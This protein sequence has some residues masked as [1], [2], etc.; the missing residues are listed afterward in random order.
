M[1]NNLHYTVNFSVKPGS[2]FQTLNEQMN[3]VTASTQKTTF[4]FGDL[5]KKLLSFNQALESVRNLQS[6]L[7]ETIQPGIAL[8]TSLTDLSAITGLTGKSLDAI[9]DAARAS[10]EAFGTDAAQNVESYK[11][12]LSQLSPD[13]AKNAEAL[14][15][16]GDHVNTL[17]KT[18]GGSTVA[19]TE[20]LTTAMNQYGVSLDDP[21]QASKVMAEMMNTMAAAAKEGSAE[22]PQIKAALENVGMVAKTTGVTFSETNAAIQVLDKAGKKGAEGGIALR[23][24][25]STL[26]EGRFLPKQTKAELEAAGVSIAQL[27][28]KSSPLSNRLNALKPIIS[29]TALITKL[30]GKENSAAAIALINGTEAIDDYNKKIQNTNT[31]VEQAKVVMGSYAEQMKRKAASWDNW[32]IGL[33]GN[34]QSILPRIQTAMSAL[35]GF[36]Q[37]STGLNALS[38]LIRTKLVQSLWKATKAF[39]AKTL[40]IQSDTAATALNAVATTRASLATRIWTGIQRTFNMVLK[41]NPIGSTVAALALL[42]GGVIAATAAFSAYNKNKD[43]AKTVSNQLNS[44]ILIEQ[45]GLNDLFEQLER[46]NPASE[47]RKELIEE[48][49]AKYPGLLDYQRLE[50]A[51]EKDIEKAR[52]EAND[53]LERTITLSAQ[54][55]QKEAF[56]TKVGEGEKA[57]ADR[58]FNEG[59]KEE[60]VSAFLSAIKQQT[61]N[62]VKSGKYKAGLFSGASNPLIDDIIHQVA[63]AN[64]GAKTLIGKSGLKL[65][66]LIDAWATGLKG[67]QDYQRYADIKLGKTPTKQEATKENAKAPNGGTSS[68]KVKGK[69]KGFGTAAA[70]AAKN[71]QSSADRLGSLSSNNQA[72]TTRS[73]TINKLV[74]TLIVKVERLPES[75]E[76]IKDA[77]SEALL[78]AV[79]DYNLAT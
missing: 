42:V 64:P 18:M 62:T 25:L 43:T 58:L 4:Y 26:S 11:L 44:Q 60:E 29:D 7:N 23:N 12:L 78:L 14:K 59:S 71:T 53:E 73:L 2:I 68:D 57:L 19:A 72:G 3:Q 39:F 1:N 30:F 67:E 70:N 75:K 74:E 63:A 13:I 16:M 27:G 17:S 65:R 33:F 79:N 47:R 8:N 35:G 56:M 61:E 50:A 40:G 41:A 55:A 77:V 69:L 54:K 76:R 36:W 21:M 49:N 6:A 32:K 34:I 37:A 38:G 28:D 31:A 24:A 46:T 10:A 66:S 20:V 15:F 5:W 48:L 45:R 9:S 51:S 22:L 52:R